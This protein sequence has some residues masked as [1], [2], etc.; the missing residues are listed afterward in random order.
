MLKFF[1]KS[2]ADESIL[3]KYKMS[4]EEYKDTISTLTPQE[5]KVYNEVVQGYNTEKISKKLK[6]TKN[7]VNS[8]MKPIF[9]K[10]NVHSKVELIIAYGNIYNLVNDVNND[11]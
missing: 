8:Y 9:K 7:T 10:L 1:K 2:K 11:D 4:L 6:L 3:P 5:L